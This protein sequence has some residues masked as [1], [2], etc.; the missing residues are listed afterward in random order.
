MKEL[1]IKSV[2][3]WQTFK[4]TT[5]ML[6]IILFIMGLIVSSYGL[7][8]GGLDKFLNGLLG[9]VIVAF[10]MAPV[11]ALVV[12]VAIWLYNLVAGWVGGFKINVEEE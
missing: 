8:M 11:Y 7:V 3:P 5:L 6:A 1:E 12:I 9:T 4:I 2:K 10:V